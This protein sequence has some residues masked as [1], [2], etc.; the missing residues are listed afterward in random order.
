VGD[1]LD[2]P[3]G[4]A[5][6][7]DVAD[8]GLV[9]HL[10]V[11][12]ADPT[13]RA[14]ADQE[15]P[16]QPAVGDGSAAG[17]GERLRRDGGD[18]AAGRGPGRLG[19]EHGRT[20]SG[21]VPPAEEVEGFASK[22]LRGEG[23]ERCAAAFEVV[24]ARRPPH[25]LEGGGGDDL[26]GQ[27]RRGGLVGTRHRLD[28]RG[29]HPFDGPRPVWG[30]RRGVGEEHAARDLADLVA[31]AADALEGAGDAGRG[32][33][34]D[35]EVDRAH[36]DAE[37]EAAGGDDAGEA[38]ALEVVLDDRPLLLG[39]RAVVGLGDDDLGSGAGSGL[40]HDLGRVLVRPR[41]GRRRPGWWRS[42]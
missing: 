16:E 30:G 32:L 39:D 4:R 18:G 17:D 21:G 26:L 35:D 20:R 29:S 38:A 23:R 14:L 24:E 7:E 37:L 41:P 34:L 1:V 36:V 8:P 27:G 31:G 13:A 3:A 6:G 11:E 42:R 5:E 40:G 28:W 15:D 9:D 2:P 10:L 25:R 33:D 19:G 22:A 12:L